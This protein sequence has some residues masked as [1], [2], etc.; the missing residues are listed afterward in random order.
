MN[1]K[2]ITGIL[3]GSFYHPVAVIFPEVIQHSEMADSFSKILGAG[4][5]FLNTNT[6]TTTTG[7]HNEIYVEVYGESHSLKIVSREEDLELVKKCLGLTY[8]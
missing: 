4:F 1:T 7:T 2:Y 6:T 5:V 3:K 8:G